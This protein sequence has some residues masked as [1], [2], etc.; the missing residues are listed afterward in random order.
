VRLK[1]LVKG[2]KKKGH[3]AS[4]SIILTKSIPNSTRI[5]ISKDQI[6]SSMESTVKMASVSS[7]L[8]K[9]LKSKMMA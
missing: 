9:K 2:K 4:K 7:K 8:T 5:N 6:I 1:K 3:K